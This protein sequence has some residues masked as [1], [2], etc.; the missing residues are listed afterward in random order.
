M[1]QPRNIIDL[2]KA[3]CFLLHIYP[4]CFTLS[5][6]W[7]PVFVGYLLP[8]LRCLPFNLNKASLAVLTCVQREKK[9]SSLK[10]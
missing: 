8:S 9:C 5:E 2:K 10:D 7:H 1:A 3:Y 6:P 4:F